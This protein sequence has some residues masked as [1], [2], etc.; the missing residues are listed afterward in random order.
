[1]IVILVLAQTK[2]DELLTLCQEYQV[3]WLTKKIE[4]CLFNRPDINVVE[5][6]LLAE[7]FD[8][9]KLKR[10][11]IEQLCDIKTL[12]GDERFMRLPRSIIYK[13]ERQYVI[14]RVGT[15]QPGLIAFLDHLF[16]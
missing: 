3:N 13:L 6:L 16:G 9:K 1:M 11:L 8:L 14:Y 15:A 5:R 12:E 2:F 10:M 4:N 7:K